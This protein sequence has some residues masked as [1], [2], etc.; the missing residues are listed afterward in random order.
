MRNMYKIEANG[1][2]TVTNAAS[3][4]GAVT[5]GLRT[6][7]EGGHLKSAED[8]GLLRITAIIVK[9][10]VTLNEKADIAA[11][12]D[13]DEPIKLRQ[14]AARPVVRQAHHPLDSA[15]EP[16]EGAYGVTQ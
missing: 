6:L 3:I 2:V 12:R 11:Y 14:K 16:V 4:N 9:R 8:K 13:N 10:D 1:W 7:A 5:A 15:P